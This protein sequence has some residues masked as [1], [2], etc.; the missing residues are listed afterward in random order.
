MK[1]PYKKPGVAVLEHTKG[2]IAANSEEQKEQVEKY[3]E[4][5]QSEKED[6]S[7]IPRPL[8]NG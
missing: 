1:K 3:W 7:N 6:C 2:V 5:L 4:I 8:E